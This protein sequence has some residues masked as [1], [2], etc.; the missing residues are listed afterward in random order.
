M[1]AALP[2]LDPNGNRFKPLTY[3]EGHDP[4]DP[5]TGA[6]SGLI[7]TITGVMM[8]VADIPTALFK[9]GTKKAGRS[10]DSAYRSPCGNNY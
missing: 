7:G 9:P 2:Y 5:I 4:W 6:S 10:I 1:L 8:G 3:L